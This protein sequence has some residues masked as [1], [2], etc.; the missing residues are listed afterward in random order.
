MCSESEPSKT[1][2]RLN[3]RLKKLPS[4]YAT[5]WSDILACGS[6][7]YRWHAG[8]VVARLLVRLSTRCTAR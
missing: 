1:D 3:R 8:L 7:V 5:S 4:V 2:H 6:V